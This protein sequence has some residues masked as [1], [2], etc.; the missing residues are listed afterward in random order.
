MKMV[1]PSYAVAMELRKSDAELDQ[2]FMAL[3]GSKCWQWLQYATCH[4]PM[5]SL[6]FARE[7]VDSA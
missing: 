7:L 5:E 6:A 1:K 4:T 3:P 2:K